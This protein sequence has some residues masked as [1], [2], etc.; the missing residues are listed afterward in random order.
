ML[1]IREMEYLLLAHLSLRAK[2]FRILTL[3]E[4]ESIFLG[5][6]LS[7]RVGGTAKNTAHLCH[8]HSRVP[9]FFKGK[10]GVKYWAS[11]S[12]RF[13]RDYGPAIPHHVVTI[14]M[15]LS[16]SLFPPAF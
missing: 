3:R 8:R 14:L 4:V 15:I 2:P 13:L 10:G 1:N 6:P 16:K 11:L 5:S 9:L 12:P 7:G